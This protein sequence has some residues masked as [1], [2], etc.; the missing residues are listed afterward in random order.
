[1]RQPEPNSE[2]IVMSR[3]NNTTLLNKHRPALQFIQDSPVKRIEGLL[4][5]RL[6]LGRRYQS[7]IH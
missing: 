2:S 4:P 6:T 1:M 3:L 5:F 7:S